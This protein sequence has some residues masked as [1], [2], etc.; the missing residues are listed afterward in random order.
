MSRQLIT[1]RSPTRQVADQ[2]ATTLTFVDNDDPYIK[3]I[4]ETFREKKTEKVYWK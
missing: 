1:P 4:T 3:S 2:P